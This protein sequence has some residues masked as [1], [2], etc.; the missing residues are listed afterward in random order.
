M[1]KVLTLAAISIAASFP[2]AADSIGPGGYDNHP[3]M[4]GGWFMGP[5]MMVLIIGIIVFAV[6]YLVRHFSGGNTTQ[7]PSLDRAMEILNE[8]YAKGEIDKAEYQERK[9]ALSD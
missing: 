7:A 5:I 2:V 1:K 6:A 3:M 9:A 8:R 4:W